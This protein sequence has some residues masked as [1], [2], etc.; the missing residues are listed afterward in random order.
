MAEKIAVT[1]KGKNDLA[2]LTQADTL[3]VF[4][5]RDT[6]W[7]AR[8]EIPY[9][10][11]LS[12]NLQEIRN[13]VRNLITKLDDCNIIVSQSITGLVYN[14]FDRMG[15]H[16][17][18]VPTF[19]KTVLND[20]L[21]DIN[22][23]TENIERNEAIPTTPIETVDGIYF[24]DLI[25]LQA[26]RPDISSKKALQP[27]LHNT[28]FIKLDM[29]CSH[30]PPWL[31]NTEYKSAFDIVNKKSGSAMLVTITKKICK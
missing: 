29:L 21:M 6:D 5:K 16:I 1:F 28:P 9:Q 3:M 20:I 23:N 17:F 30:L 7:I 24:L 26:N 14:V 13:Q 25:Q 4:E 27:F 22:N 19:Q 2:N 15:F 11:D 10:I 31:E 18:E 8:K 12:T